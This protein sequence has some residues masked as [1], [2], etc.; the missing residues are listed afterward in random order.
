MIKVF[1]ANFIGLI[2][3]ILNGFFLPA[4]LKIDQ[5]AYLK[6]FSLYVSFVGILHFGFLDGIY[7]KYGGKFKDVLNRE[8]LKFEHNFLIL[9][10]LLITFMFL[11]IAMIR[12]DF[13]LLAFALAIIPIDMQTYFSFLYQS[14]GEMGTFAKVKTAYPTIILCLNLS[15]IFLVGINHYL[16]FVIAIL[17][18]HYVVFLI[19]EFIYNKD[20]KTKG[21]TKVKVKF[22]E[23]LPLIECKIIAWFCSGKKIINYFRIWFHR[24]QA[25]Y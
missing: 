5:Y 6:T 22:N 8:E 13:I 25:Y 21:I 24:L 14:I 16:P 19:F 18:S 3:G 2:V 23:G 20:F 9:F 1:S 7:L 15:L 10:Q 17:I 11:L 12:K 4:F